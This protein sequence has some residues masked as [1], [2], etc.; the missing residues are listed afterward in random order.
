MW[1]NDRTDFDTARDK[2]RNTYTSR[3]NFIQKLSLSSYIETN[4]IL[5]F[6]LLFFIIE[7]LTARNNSLSKS[8]F[9]Y[10]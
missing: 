8:V 6:F 10:F 5:D 4:I 3:G 9:Y 2:W 1:L 7:Y